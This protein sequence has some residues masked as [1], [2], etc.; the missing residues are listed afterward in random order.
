MKHIYKVWLASLIGTFA[1]LSAMPVHAAATV[2]MNPGNS[3][4]TYLRD[5]DVLALDFSIQST[6][7]DKLNAFTLAKT[8]TAREG[9]DY[10]VVSLWADRGDAGFQ[11]WGYDQKLGN[12]TF[13]SGQWVFSNM[14]ANF[15]SAT[16][17]FFVSIETGNLPGDKTLQ[18][19]LLAGGDDG[20]KVYETGEQGIFLASQV[21]S[22][23]PDPA[24]SNSVS[25]K[26]EKADRTAPKALISGIS[27]NPTMPTMV[28]VE[29]G[30]V[31]I[32]GEARDR[33]GS[34]VADVRLVV[35]GQQVQAQMTDTAF[36][37]WKAL[38]VPTQTYE[39]LKLEVF[40]TDG[41]HEYTSPSYYA[42]IDTRQVEAV[43]SSFTTDE[44][45]LIVGESTQLRVTVRDPEGTVLPNRVVTFTPVRIEDDLSAGSAIT[46]ANG[47]AEVTVT[48]QSF[49]TSNVSAKVGSVEL[50]TITIIVLNSED[51][52]PPPVIVEEEYAYGDLIKGSLP[53]VYY[54]AKDG[55]RH[56][57]VNSDVYT[58]WYGAN[59]SA[60]KT[61][62]DA[63]LA[64]IPLGT[65]VSFKP[66]SLIKVPSVPA[67]YVVDVGPILR[68]IETEAIAKELFGETWN[69]QVRDLSEAL[70]FGYDIGISVS[71]PDQL[72][73]TAFTHPELTIDSEL[74][75]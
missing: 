1:P 3:Q 69:K 65:P 43:K 29:A 28:T 35:N 12:G 55:K 34:N 41:A 47:Y 73:S 25:I 63:D 24:F 31:T 60:V 37:K 48:V 4:F 75:F 36:A 15:V 17:R 38:Y 2:I 23:V 27:V 74:G 45:R 33:N 30:Q 6:V 32:T 70:L 61:I 64:S 72:D 57:F 22:Q 20:D 52:V 56:V 42:F 62:S 9:I 39:T 50:G 8:G 5:F 14:N 54:Y 7:G 13:V 26:D 51:V 21:I 11:G 53:A 49:G 71:R 66:G 68:H 40:A 58:S 18:F 19:A 44:D 46:D 16:E 59:F 10:T 67:V